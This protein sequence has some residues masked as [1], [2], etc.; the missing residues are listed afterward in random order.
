MQS[1]TLDAAAGGQLAAAASPA[2]TALTDS[3]R[4]PSG[5]YGPQI[6]CHIMT[7]S[8]RGQ[9]AAAG[10]PAAT[11]LTDSPR[12][13]SGMYGPQIEC[14][15]MTASARG[16]L[17]AAASP[18]ATPLTDS[19]RTPSAASAR[20]QLAAAGSP[21][22]TAL[23][24][25]SRT[26]SAALARGQLAA[27]ASPTATALTDSP[28]TPSAASARGQ[29]AAVGSLNATALT[30]SPRTP[31]ATGDVSLLC[32]PNTHID[33]TV[34]GSSL[35]VSTLCRSGHTE[36]WCSQPVIRQKPVGNILVA[37]AILFTGCSIKKALRMLSSMG[38]ASFCYKTFFIIQKAFLLPAIEKDLRTN[39]MTF[40]LSVPPQHHP[41]F[42]LPT[43]A[44]APAPS[45]LT[46]PT[47][48]T[49]LTNLAG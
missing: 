46:R 2:A 1:V 24:D 23:T 30:D 29:L 8:A 17:A 44:Y 33:K 47:T 12:T 13:P 42:H 45:Q 26:P 5:M 15:I 32:S 34:Q 41:P 19:P 38:I 22:A 48:V 27:A 39:F 35:Q 18:T 40:A 14:Y 3:P 28:R 7:A 31:S 6:D 16:Q 43:Y 11:A 37:A 49:A 10:S 25:S 21:A 4:T 20:G 9:L 36:T